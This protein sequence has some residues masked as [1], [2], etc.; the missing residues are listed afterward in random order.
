[1]NARLRTHEKSQVLLPWMPEV[2]SIVTIQPEARNALFVQNK[3]NEIISAAQGIISHELVQTLGVARA[4]RAFMFLI[5]LCTIY[6][7]Q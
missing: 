4:E 5:L 1:M 2:I 6:F 7:K 3:L